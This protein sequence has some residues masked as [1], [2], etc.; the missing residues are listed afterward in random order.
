MSQEGRRG[1]YVDC[2]GDIKEDEDKEM[3]AGLHS[4]KNG[5]DIDNSSLWK[6]VRKGTHGRDEES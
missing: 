1:Q 2:D 5:E 3:G 6:A 4:I